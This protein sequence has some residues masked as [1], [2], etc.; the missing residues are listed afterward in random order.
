MTYL[1]L[2]PSGPADMGRICIYWLNIRNHLP[3][4]L[5]DQT[6]VKYNTKQ[7]CILRLF[8]PSVTYETAMVS[9]KGGQ[10]R[11]KFRTS[12]RRIWTLKMSNSL[13]LH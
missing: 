4:L 3:M 5:R 11:D 1:T 9:N 13:L 2:A 7:A 6:I 8:L 12:G 10:F